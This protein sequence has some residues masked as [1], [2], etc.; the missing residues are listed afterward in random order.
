MRRRWS[1]RSSR[2][3][4]TLVT[5]LA[6][7]RLVRES[8]RMRADIHDGP[9]QTLQSE[10]G[11]S[12]ARPRQPSR[13]NLLQRTAGPYR[14]VIFDIVGQGST[15][16]HVRFAPK[17][18]QLLIDREIAR[19]GW[20][21]RAPAPNGSQ[22]AWGLVRKRSTTMPHKSTIHAVTAIGIDMDKNT[23][24]M[25]GLDSC[26]AI[27][28]REKVSRGRIASRLA[29][30]QP[31]LVG[32]EAGMATHML[33]A[34]LPRLATMLKQVPPTY[35]KP[36]R[37]GHKNDFRDAHAVAEAVQRPL[38]PASFQPKPTSNWTCK[39]CTECGRALSAS[40]PQ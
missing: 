14:W 8:G 9:E 3:V 30:L 38:R 33:L 22:S 17:A 20:A 40:E 24:H 12:N 27:V 34:S 13:R 29:N 15:S 1:D 6:R 11:Y 5:Q 36:F 19:M 16:Q 10:A 32:I 7:S 2:R 37:Q 26:G 25:I 28:L 23:L 39:R 31:C 4:R 21:G 35:A 18:T